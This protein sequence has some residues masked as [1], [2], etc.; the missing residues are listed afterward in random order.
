VAGDRP[1]THPG[2]L[3]ASSSDMH[4]DVAAGQGALHR[5]AEHLPVG[6][7]PLR[8]GREPEEVHCLRGEIV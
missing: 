4:T 3:P 7:Y 6:Y 8:R 1:S 5:A 2:G